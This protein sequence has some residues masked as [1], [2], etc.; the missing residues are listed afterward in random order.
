MARWLAALLA[1]CFGWPAPKCRLPR[2]VP[3]SLFGPV[4]ASGHRLLI[5]L[6]CCLIFL[7]RGDVANLNQPPLAH[8]RCPE[9]MKPKTGG[10]RSKLNAHARRAN[11][12][13]D[14]SAARS[15]SGVCVPVLALGSLGPTGNSPFAAPLETALP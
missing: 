4:H 15:P 11:W 8:F 3:E 6:S 1:G 5:P 2:R 12:D 13:R 14:W 9:K 7:L 10:R